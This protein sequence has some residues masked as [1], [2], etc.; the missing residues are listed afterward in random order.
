G[1]RRPDEAREQTPEGSDRHQSPRRALPRS[2]IDGPGRR[3]SPSDLSQPF[4]PVEATLR[5]K[6]FWPTKNSTRQGSII[7]VDT[8]SKRC[9]STRSN[10]SLNASS[11]TASVRFS[12]EF[13]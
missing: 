2:E 11:P 7:S 4:I 8:A 12:G 1:G 9:A 3:G 5:T 13:R 6:Y 10:W